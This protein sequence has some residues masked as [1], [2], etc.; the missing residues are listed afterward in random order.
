MFIQKYCII[1]L[2]FFGF[3]AVAQFEKLKAGLENDVIGLKQAGSHVG[4]ASGEFGK[5]VGSAMS[6]H[7]VKD[8]L[9]VGAENLY[10]TFDIDGVPY[11][12]NVNTN[13]SYKNS[14]QG[15]T[16]LIE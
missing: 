16:L 7:R 4:K 8:S 3:S 12:L 9:D 13:S 5:G 15:N 2:L 1:G 10:V 6:P 11:K 14:T